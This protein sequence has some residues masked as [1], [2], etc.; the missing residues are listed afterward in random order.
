MAIQ[1]EFLLDRQGELYRA[2]L[3]YRLALAAMAILVILLVV[4]RV[5][6]ATLCAAVRSG[7]E[8]AEAGH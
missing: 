2:G 3:R 4:S 7:C 8:I 6:V 1:Q 5:E